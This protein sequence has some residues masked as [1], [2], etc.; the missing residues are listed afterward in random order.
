VPEEVQQSE[1]YQNFWQ[2]LAQGELF[3][4]RFKRVNKQGR[5][6]WLEASYNPVLDERGQVIKVIKFATD[7]TSQVQAEQ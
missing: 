6:L 5:T 4:Q 3:Q 2:K 7:I 1:H